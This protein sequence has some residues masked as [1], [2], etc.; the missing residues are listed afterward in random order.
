[1][2]IIIQCKGQPIFCLKQDER[3]KLPATSFN[4]NIEHKNEGEI[5]TGMKRWNL[6]E[7]GRQL[8]VLVCGRNTSSLCS[9]LGPSSTDLYKEKLKR[10]SDT[11]YHVTSPNEMTRLNRDTL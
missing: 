3:F 7:R 4:A 10:Y 1:M 6:V 2:K 8:L 9:Y 5:P 11:R